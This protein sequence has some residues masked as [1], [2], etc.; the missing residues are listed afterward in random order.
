MAVLCLKNGQYRAMAY[1]LEH[2]N[3]AQS[4]TAISSCM[5]SIDELERR[6]GIDFFCNLPDDIETTVEA[7]TPSTSYWE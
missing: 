4:S 6:T 7:E 2:K 1:W 3:S 5:I